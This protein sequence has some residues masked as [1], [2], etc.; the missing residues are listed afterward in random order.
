[1]F[2]ANFLL[3]HDLSQFFY[4]ATIMLEMTEFSERVHETQNVLR[5]LLDFVCYWCLCVEDISMEGGGVTEEFLIHPCNPFSVSL[6]T[7]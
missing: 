1:L 6:I 7:S 5:V 3:F 4:V 2:F